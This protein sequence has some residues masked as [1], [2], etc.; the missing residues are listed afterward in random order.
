LSGHTVV[1]RPR[2]LYSDSFRFAAL[3]R[4]NRTGIQPGDMVLQS[5]GIRDASLT[6]LPEQL[7]PYRF[8]D[9]VLVSLRKTMQHELLDMELDI[10]G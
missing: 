3:F 7:L 1:Y 4:L 5:Q 6:E 8:T 10:S 2:H 9:W